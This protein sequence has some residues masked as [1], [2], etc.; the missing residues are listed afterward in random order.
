[1]VATRRE[2]SSFCFPPSSLFDES[3]TPCSRPLSV[4]NRTASRIRR[5]HSLSASVTHR[6]FSSFLNFLS[7]SRILLSDKKTLGRLNTDVNILFY[8]ES[9][10]STC[11][12]NSG[13]TFQPQIIT[14][15]CSSDRPDIQV[16]ML[17]RVEGVYVDLLGLL[18]YFSEV[19]INKIKNDLARKKRVGVGHHH[20]TTATIPT[21][22]DDT[23]VSSS[24]SRF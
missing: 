24:S 2:T 14:T 4:W 12:L 22:D 5:F 6:I 17:Q 13:I 20:R 7:P 16:Q 19:P 11:E 18:N 8:S 21:H 23:F 1:M 10:N 15:T 9:V 3:P